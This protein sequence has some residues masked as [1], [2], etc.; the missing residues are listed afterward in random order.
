MRRLSERKVPNMDDK[1]ISVL[2]SVGII[3][4]AA[5]VVAATIAKGWPLVWTLM[6]VFPFVTGSISLY[7]ASRD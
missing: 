5:W 2:I 7:D 3:L 4:F 1:V 6:A